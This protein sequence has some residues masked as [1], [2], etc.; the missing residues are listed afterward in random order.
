M[1]LVKDL[2]VHKHTYDIYAQSCFAHFVC[3]FICGKSNSTSFSLNL[4]FQIKS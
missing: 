2:S 3:T 1:T 4:A